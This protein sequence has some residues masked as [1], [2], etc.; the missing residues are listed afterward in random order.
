MLHI[1]NSLFGGAFKTPSCVDTAYFSVRTWLPNSQTNTSCQRV[2]A[3]H[4]GSAC[5][6]PSGPAYAVLS[7]RTPVNKACYLHDERAWYYAR[8]SSN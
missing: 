8:V 2:Y 3:Q 4:P 7:P 6:L 1:I 5:P